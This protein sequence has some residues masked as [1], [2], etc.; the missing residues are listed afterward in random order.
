MAKKKTAK[1]ATASKPAVAPQPD[2]P[3]P[4]AVKADLDVTLER[5]K[6]QLESALREHLYHTQESL[7]K[8]VNEVAEDLPE[9]LKLKPKEQAELL[10]AKGAQFKARAEA[11]RLRAVNKSWEQFEVIL[12]D[13]L[14]VAIASL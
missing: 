2:V 6:D 13:L 3:P 4:A 1:K 14:K 12:A 10:K 9:I 7:K 8:F 11:L 5:A